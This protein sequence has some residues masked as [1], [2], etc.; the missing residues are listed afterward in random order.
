M[1]K[2]AKKKVY[3]VRHAEW[4]LAIVTAASTEEATVAAAKFW[5]APWGKIA[6]QCE[7]ERTLPIFN[8]ICS[9]C[10]GMFQ[11]GHIE[12]TSICDK[13]LQKIRDENIELQRAERRKKQMREWAKKYPG[14]KKKEEA[15]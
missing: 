8:N 10:G 12:G 5:G 14:M 6:W 4:G 3:F 15:V 13:C 1:S 7:I 2:L 11:G 9:K